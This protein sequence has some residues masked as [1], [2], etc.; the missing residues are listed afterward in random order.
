MT[1]KDK[2]IF[3]TVSVAVVLILFLGLMRV[4]ASSF[5]IMAGV[6]LL[7]Y[8]I[9]GVCFIAKLKRSKNKAVRSAMAINGATLAGSLKHISGLP[10]AKNVMVDVYYGPEKIVFKKD[11]QKITVSREKVTS[12]DL[13]TGGNGTRDALR[14]AASGKYV[15]GGG[16]GAALGAAASV[17]TNLVISYVSD[18]KPKYITLDGSSGGFLPSKIVKDFSQSGKTVHSSIE[19]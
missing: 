19:L 15:F 13:V 6:I 8:V 4:S 7:A 2:I 5:G 10:I 3:I 14:G 17:K 11:G 12:I 1:K 9:F 16:V 18:G